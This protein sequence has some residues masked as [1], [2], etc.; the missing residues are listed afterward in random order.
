[1]RLAPERQLEYDQVVEFALGWASSQPAI[2]ALALVG[3]YARAEA[4]M[5]SDIDLVLLAD[6]PEVYVAGTDWIR[7]AAGRSGKIIRSKAWGPLR[8][9][10]V[11]L[12]SGLVVE[13]GFAPTSWAS[14]DPLDDGTARVVADG[15]R[16]LYDPEGLLDRLATA[17]AHLRA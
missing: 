4:S 17:V 6:E 1:M 12:P 15:F 7:S 11:E 9:R 14:V 16:I 5:S 3:S 8:E 10:R 13:Y 2:R